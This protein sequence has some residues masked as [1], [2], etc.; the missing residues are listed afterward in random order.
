M[1][2][3]KPVIKVGDKVLINKSGDKYDG[4][5]ATVISQ[6]LS[7]FIIVLASTRKVLESGGKNVTYKAEDLQR[8]EDWQF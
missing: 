2:V 8:L 4:Y 1:W 3:P 7:G 5:K 6:S